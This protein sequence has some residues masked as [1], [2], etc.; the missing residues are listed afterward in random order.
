M[1][2]GS[3]P[4]EDHSTVPVVTSSLRLVPPYQVTLMVSHAVF[5]LRKTMLNFSRCLPTTGGR[6][7]RYGVGGGGGA[8]SRASWRNGAI[9]L[10]RCLTHV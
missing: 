1:G 2:S 10:T 6:P 8:K 4:V 5:G 9:K 3:E 7:S